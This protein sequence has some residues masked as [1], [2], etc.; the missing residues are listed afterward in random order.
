MLFYLILCQYLGH[1]DVSLSTLSSLSSAVSISF[2]F[3]FFVLLLLN[4]GLILIMSVL[5][6]CDFIDSLGDIRVVVFVRI[7]VLLVEFGCYS[8]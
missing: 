7:L 3:F 2:F 4:L 6:L 8:A 5:F 1:C